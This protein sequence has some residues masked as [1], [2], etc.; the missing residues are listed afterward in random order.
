VLD[1]FFFLLP[2]GRMIAPFTARHQ[3]SRLCFLWL[4]GSALK[5]S[6]AGPISVTD[7]DDC[8]A[9]LDLRVV[10]I[11]SGRLQARG[12]MHRDWVLLRAVFGRV[13]LRG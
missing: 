9:C 1:F 5:C 3:E 8:C 2:N 6:G 7:C 10:S 13:W 4:F 12:P 11:T